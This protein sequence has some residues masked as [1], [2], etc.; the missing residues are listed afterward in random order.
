MSSFNDEL[1]AI[2]KAD[3]IEAEVVAHRRKQL[4]EKQIKGDFDLPHLQSIH[5]YLFQDFPKYWLENSKGI[6]VMADLPPQYLD[7]E[8]GRLRDQ[9]DEW[10]AW[11]KGREYPTLE[12]EVLTSFYSRMD[13]SSLDRLETVLKEANPGT[14][15]KLNPEQF[16]E[17]IS[18]IY[19][20]LDYIHP[21]VE[22][23]SRT[24][25]EFTRQL[26]EQSGYKLNW[27]VFN[28]LEKREQLYASRD[29]SLVDKALKDYRYLHGVKYEIDKTF[30][31]LSNRFESMVDLLK[32]E[33]AVQSL[34]LSKTMVKVEDGLPLAKMKE[35]SMKK[36]YSR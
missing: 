2:E 28:T 14:L 24:L 3:A 31:K 8:A 18:K 9:V 26:S 6:E 35:P 25:R 32:K 5:E 36:G 19:T 29:L 33:G 4:S 30:A 1:N 15:S 20:E 10:D 11:K 7:F 22:G 13:D 21:F 16:V 17:K 34:G 23:N 27:G 12:N